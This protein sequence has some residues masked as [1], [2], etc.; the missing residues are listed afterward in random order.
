VIA[1]EMAGHAPRVEHPEYSGG[2]GGIRLGIAPRLGAPGFGGLSC[3]QPRYAVEQQSVVLRR[4][5]RTSA[6]R[7][8]L[9]LRCRG[10]ENEGRER[11]QQ[12]A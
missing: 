4:E 11:G 7:V 3:I 6:E 2:A 8:D 5:A 9:G 1:H 12:A 10:Q